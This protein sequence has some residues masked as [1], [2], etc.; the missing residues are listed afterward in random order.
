[1]DSSAYISKS[2]QSISVVLRPAVLRYSSTSL[3]LISSICP[4]IHC[5]SPPNLS[6]ARVRTRLALNCPI[7]ILGRISRVP[8]QRLKSTTL[9]HLFLGCT[10]LWRQI[11]RCPRCPQL[12]NHYLSDADLFL[13]ELLRDYAVSPSL[14]PTQRSCR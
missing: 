5:S 10:R 9:W 12:L 3:S 8:C 6:C 13:A 14:S 11:R 2:S 4:E 1:M 7:V